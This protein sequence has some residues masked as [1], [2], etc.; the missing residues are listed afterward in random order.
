MNLATHQK[1]REAISAID[2]HRVPI[3]ASGALHAKYAALESRV[4]EFIEFARDQRMLVSMHLIQNRAKITADIMGIPS[5]KGP[6]G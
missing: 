4:T 3:S 6:N 1:N 5:F 2:R